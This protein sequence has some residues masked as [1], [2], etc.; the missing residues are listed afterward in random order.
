MPPQRV[1][2]ARSNVVPA[3]T[4]RTTALTTAAVLV[5]GDGR[6][7]LHVEQGVVPGVT[8]L[9]GEQTE[10]VDL[11]TVGQGAPKTRL[12][13]DAAQIGPVALRFEAEHPGAGLPAVADLTTGNAAGRIMAT[14]GHRRRDE[15]RRRCC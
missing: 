7:A 14:F 1:S 10:G 4:P 6:A 8:D 3:A 5:V 12:V 15:R 9:A 13:F 11:R 2:L